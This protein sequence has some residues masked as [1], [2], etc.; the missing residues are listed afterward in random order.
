MSEIEPKNYVLPLLASHFCDRYRE[1]C[2]LIYDK[3][4][5]MA[6][7]YQPYRFE[8]LPIEDLQLPS[9]NETEQSFR[10][11]WKLFYDT[12]EIE[13]RHNP[14]CRMSMMP[15]RYWKYMTEFGY[16]DDG[17]RQ[18]ESGKETLNLKIIE[19]E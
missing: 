13:G 19:G 7:V 10:R 4:H 14:K 17:N 9:P 1:E 11:L 12:I 8:I 16:G 6:L 2:F 5:R 18:L 3:T 15:K